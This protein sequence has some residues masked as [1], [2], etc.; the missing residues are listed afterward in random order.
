MTK[1][2]FIQPDGIEHLV[3]ADNGDSI[4]TAAINNNV[5]GIDGDCGGNCACATCHVYIRQSISS[6]ADEEEKTMLG[7]AD[8]ATSDSRL[9]C[10]IS[11]S[12]DLDGLRVY[13]PI[14]Q[15]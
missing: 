6:I 2:V 3:E 12:G 9:G 15:H 1:I 14:A 11:V 7:I 10:Q 4:M 13:L 8:N 5:P